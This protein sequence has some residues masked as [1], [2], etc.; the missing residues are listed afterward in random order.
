MSGGLDLSLVM[1]ALIWVLTGFKAEQVNISCF[2]S[3]PH[4]TGLN[5]ELVVD[6]LRTEIDL[7]LNFEIKHFTAG[8]DLVLCLLHDQLCQR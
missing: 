5:L 7:G 3:T 2:Y 6:K 4:S 8:N 1:A